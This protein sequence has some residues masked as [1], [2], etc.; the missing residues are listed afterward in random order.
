[1]SKNDIDFVEEKKKIGYTVFAGGML[2]VD[3]RRY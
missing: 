1:M 3:K 2:D